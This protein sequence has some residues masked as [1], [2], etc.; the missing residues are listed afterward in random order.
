VLCRPPGGRAAGREPKRFRS[1]NT[2]LV[3]C[4]MRPRC[5][6]IE[7]CTADWRKWSFRSRPHDRI[8]SLT[9][10]STASASEH[11]CTHAAP[12]RSAFSLVGERLHCTAVQRVNGRCG[13]ELIVTR[14]CSSG[15]STAATAMIAAAKS[16]N[17]SPCSS[18]RP[19]TDAPTVA[20]SLPTG[21]EPAA[22]V[23]LRKCARL[24][25]APRLPNGPLHQ[26]GN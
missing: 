12:H 25:V 15:D 26:Y 20:Y 17:C 13:T 10:R 1:S 18:G 16:R 7:L 6:S 4:L 5:G 3:V 19:L 14:I 2:A 24:P 8:R 9:N 11:G 21:T 22:R 23:A